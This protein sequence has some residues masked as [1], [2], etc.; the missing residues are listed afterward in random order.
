MHQIVGWLVG[1]VRVD[2]VLAVGDG[3]PR[4]RYVLVGGAEDGRAFASLREL[5]D[6]AAELV[7]EPPQ[8]PE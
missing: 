1:G 3:A 8:P 5:A 2:S 4:H 6:Y 7:A